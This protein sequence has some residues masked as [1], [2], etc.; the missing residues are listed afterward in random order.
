MAPGSGTQS[1]AENQTT[2]WEAPRQLA[3]LRGR[4][5][6]KSGVVFRCGQ[7]MYRTTGREMGQGGMG[8]V[9]LMGRRLGTSGQVQAV[10]GKVFHSD[11]LLQLRTDKAS[12]HEHDLVMAN[13]DNIAEL[14][15]PHILPHM[16][17]H[18]SPTTF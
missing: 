6:E 7:Y 1:L 10:I 13:I 17:R 16:F 5:L 12:R 4:D 11:Y 8:T 9:F 2:E 18:K 3:E 14:D 15:H